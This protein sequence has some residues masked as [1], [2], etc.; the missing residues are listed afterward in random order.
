MNRKKGNS[1]QSEPT[2]RLRKL[3][4]QYPVI[5]KGAGFGGKFFDSSVCNQIMPDISSCYFC[6]TIDGITE[7][8][9]IPDEFDPPEKHQQVLVVCDSCR[10]KLERVLEPVVQYVETTQSPSG[11]KEESD[12]PQDTSSDPDQDPGDSESRSGASTTTTDDGTF[13]DSARKIVRLIQN[14]ELPADREEIEL[15]ASNAY[16]IELAECQR[17]LDALIDHGYFIETAG[18]I[19]IPESS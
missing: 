14:R 18:K 7:Y 12:R 10:T 4:V 15:L 9:V 2:L 5:Q 3:S 11:T 1:N 6:S 19:D 8:P 17:I 16:E 13:P